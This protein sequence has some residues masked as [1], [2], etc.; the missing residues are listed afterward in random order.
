MK[1]TKMKDWDPEAV[2]QALDME[3]N[4]V[5]GEPA[6]T[7]EQVSRSKLTE[8]VPLAADV[9][10]HIMLYSEN[11]GMRWKSAVEVL[12]RVLGKATDVPLG[13]ANK[14]GELEK[15]MKKVVSGN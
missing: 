14:D 13:A 12:N 2:K 15:F 8:A 4:P 1:G 9:L 3:L 5:Q 11:E 6:K 10:L 7:P